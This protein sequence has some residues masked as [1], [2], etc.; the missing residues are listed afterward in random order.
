MIYYNVKV[1]RESDIYKKKGDIEKYFEV[2]LSVKKEEVK[3]CEI[4]E[5]KKKFNDGVFDFDEYL[6]IVKKVGY[7]NL[8]LV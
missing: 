6:E 4:K 3:E 8:E 5:L 1:Y 2:Y 7:E